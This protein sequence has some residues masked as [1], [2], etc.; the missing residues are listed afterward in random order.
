MKLDNR[1][2]SRN[3][4]L[5]SFHSLVYNLKFLWTVNYTSAQL[6][7]LFVLPLVYL[8]RVVKVANL[9]RCLPPRGTVETGVVGVADDAL[10]PGQGASRW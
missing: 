3:N 5:E 1:L 8:H 10:N 7:C 6:F 2:L 4:V 9:S